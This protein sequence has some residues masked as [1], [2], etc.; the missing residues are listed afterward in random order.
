MRTGKKQASCCVL[1]SSG[2][3]KEVR[4][5]LLQKTRA[6]SHTRCGGNR[7]DCVCVAEPKALA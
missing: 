3:A 4:K 7:V 6:Y 2:P 1:R 5:E